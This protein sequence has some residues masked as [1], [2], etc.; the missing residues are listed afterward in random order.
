[1]M[2]SRIWKL[3]HTVPKQASQKYQ[4]AYLRI[5]EAMKGSR[6][7]SKVVWPSSLSLEF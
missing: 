5:K 2:T 3:A 7:E 1:M 4:N 6:D